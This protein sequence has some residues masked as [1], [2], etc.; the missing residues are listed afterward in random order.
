MVSIISYKVKGI[1]LYSCIEQSSTV[2]Q[3]EARDSTASAMINIT[4]E[5]G[6]QEN[7]KTDDNDNPIG[8]TSMEN[9]SGDTSERESGRDD[10]MQESVEVA[11]TDDSDLTINPIGITICSHLINIIYSISILK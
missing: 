8:S 11:V 9:P 5:T 6:T 4:T 7:D 10:N 2:D 3:C 1:L